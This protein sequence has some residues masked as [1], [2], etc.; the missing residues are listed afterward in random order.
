M[1][2][3]LMK[4]NKQN[5]L[6]LIV[7]SFFLHVSACVPHIDELQPNKLLP[8]NYPNSEKLNAQEIPANTVGVKWKEY[9]TDPNLI[10]LVDTA[11][12][13]N[14]ELNIFMQEIQMAQNDIG[15]RQGAYLPSIELGA[16]AGIDK[17]G[18]YT[19]EG[20]VE[21]NHDIAPGK[22]FPDPLPNFVMGAF[23]KWEIDIW[24]KLR[25]AEKSALTTYLASKEGRNFMV[26]NLIAE[27]ANLYFELLALDN[28]LIIVE[29]N[30]GIQ[31]D[32]LDVVRL[33]KE[34]ARVTEL[35]LRRFEAQVY[36]TKSLKS[37]IQQK[38]VVTENKINFLA[39]RYPQHVNRSPKTFNNLVP[40]TIKAGIPSQLFEN[41]PDVRQAELEL[42]AADLDIKVA[43][44]NFYPS[45]NI[46]GSFGYSAYDTAR[47]LD[48][49]ESMLYSLGGGLTSPFINRKE[50]K[51]A[52]YNASS[53]QIQAVKN[54]ERT[55]LQAF[56][57][58]ANQLS[59]I[60]NLKTNYDLKAKQ[61]KALDESVSISTTLFNSARADYMEVLLTQR[62]AL[63]SKFDL[64]ETKAQQLHAAVN[65]YR[66]LGGGWTS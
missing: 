29:Q 24:H 62:E 9:F 16:D 58:V 27:M 25:D 10:S 47:I 31:S 35:A 66:S 23:A 60:E 28:Q 18:Q 39:G 54:Y 45:L 52:Y 37:E 1:R 42:V 13:S 36:K 44:A 49:P 55:V 64:V 56:I 46:T 17:V 6:K 41:R 65:I 20:V 48:T 15:A 33:K 5:L 61:V 7:V 59:S 50:I 30:I 11:L 2:S 53:K 43:K 26:T 22:S 38:I 12:E 19:R 14:Q 63:D 21:E 40:D 3:Y 4:T 51:A 57:E 32:A 34:G 8:E